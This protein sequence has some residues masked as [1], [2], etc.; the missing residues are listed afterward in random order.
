MILM[1]ALVSYLNYADEFDYPVISFFS[2]KDLKKVKKLA[3]KS[4]KDFSVT[5][6]FL[7]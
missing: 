2:K 5:K 6:S 7:I 4:K 1:F 3:D